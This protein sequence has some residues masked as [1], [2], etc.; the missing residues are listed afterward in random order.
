MCPSYDEGRNE[1]GEGVLNGRGGGGG[2]GG[3]EETLNVLNLG[4]SSLPS[5][6]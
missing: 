6:G 2:G 5:A 4:I 1:S 3:E